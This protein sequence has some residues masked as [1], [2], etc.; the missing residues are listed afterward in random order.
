MSQP[1][2]K[3]GRELILDLIN[4]TNRINRPLTFADVQFSLP[5]PIADV[6]PGLRNT[7]MTVYP[8]PGSNFIRS[9]LVSYWRLNIG[10]L[11]QGELSIIGITEDTVINN[12]NDIIQILN[13]RYNLMLTEEDVVYEDV[14][15]PSIP[16]TVTLTMAEHSYAYIDSVELT[17]SHDLAQVIY[18][19]VLDGLHYPEDATVENV[20]PHYVTAQGMLLAGTGLLGQYNITGN[21]GEA[22]GFVG[23]HRTGAG[24]PYVTP[25]GNTFNLPLANNRHWSFT[26]GVGL[27]ETARGSVLTDLYD[28]DLSVT[29]ENGQ[30][31]AATLER[32]D[33]SLVWSIEGIGP[34]IVDNAPVGSLMVA[35]NS[36]RTFFY[37]PFFPHVPVNGVGAHLGR[38]TVRLVLMPIR[39]IY[40]SPIELT[41][42]AN[43]TPA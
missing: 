18:T 10:Q 20:S 4:R 41:V 34:A 42:I 8:A 9:K 6:A 23:I 7:E 12:T 36:Q 30:S 17:F 2:N 15:L 43:I 1:L 40:V 27:I 39:A 31:F 29:H 35:Q 19:N 13:D 25:V 21:N 33:T 14:S 11:L 28:I 22:E 32:V 38:F 5:A 26:F 16:G 3:V 37:T 24:T